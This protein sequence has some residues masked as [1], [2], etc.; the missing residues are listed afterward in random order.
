MILEMVGIAYT[1]PDCETRIQHHC[2]HDTPTTQGAEGQEW[3]VVWLIRL[4]CVG[5]VVCHS[6]CFLA[7]VALRSPF[8]ALD[9]L[10]HGRVLI[11]CY[12][13]PLRQSYCTAHPTSLLYPAIHPSS[14]TP[15]VLALPFFLVAFCVS[16]VELETYAVPCGCYYLVL[17]KVTQLHS[18]WGLRMSGAASQCAKPFRTGKMTNRTSKNSGERTASKPSLIKQAP[19]FQRRVGARLLVSGSTLGFHQSRKKVDSAHSRKT[20]WCIHRWEAGLKHEG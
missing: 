8:W 10:L 2:A 1:T 4:L 18:S 5:R 17:R 13:T 6:Y 3:Q 20:R 14:Y 7:W 19:D 11:T 12:C 16:L 15:A 9:C